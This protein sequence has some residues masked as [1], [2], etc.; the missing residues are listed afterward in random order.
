[1]D[2]NNDSYQQPN[3]V[4]PYPA[5]TPYPNP[6]FADGDVDYDGDSLTLITEYKLW[7]Y[8][9]EVNHTAGRTL[10][11]LSYSDGNQYSITVLTGDYLPPQTFRAW[12]V[13][14]GYATP[15]LFTLD[16]SHIQVGVNLFDM[17][18]DTNVTFAENFY[19]GD[20]GYVSDEERDEDADGLTNYVET[21]GPG[22]A[23]WWT[24]CYTAEAAFP[25]VYAGTKPFDADSDGDLILDGADDQDFDDVPNV[26]ELS[27]SLAGNV[28][29][30]AMCANTSAPPYVSAPETTWVNPF[31]PCLPDPH[32]RTCPRYV[33]V[34]STPYPPFDP[35]WLTKRLVL[36]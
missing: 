31:N 4:L 8:T 16:G 5:K 34:G 21:T 28:A 2:L 3:T 35:D 27:R 13:A 1:V 17:D 30:Q 24:S 19:W 15:Q 9:Y 36:N 25:I 12:G 23:K 6:L 14:T 20:G 10:A 29:Q 18:R 22:S 26:M 11:P 33:V 32:S 7:K